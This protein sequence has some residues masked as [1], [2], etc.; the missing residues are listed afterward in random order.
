MPRFFIA[1]TV[2]E[3][4]EQLTLSA[5]DTHHILHVLRLK[6]GDPMTVCDGSHTIHSCI[7]EDLPSAGEALTVRIT[8]RRKGQA[9]PPYSVTLY[10]GIP[11]GDKMGTVVRMAVEL[12]VGRIVPVLCDR[13]VSRPAG[14]KGKD[15]ALRW[16]KVATAAAK[17][18]GRD[19]I[20]TVSAPLT[21]KEALAELLTSG[22]GARPEEKK[23]GEQAGLPAATAGGAGETDNQ[24]RC[25]LLFAP[26][27]GETET[28]LRSWLSAA[29]KNRPA[30]Q[31]E[32]VAFF[33]GPEGGF[34]GAEEAA[35]AAAGV[36]TVSL[37]NR[38]LRTETAA[39]AVLSMLSYE[40]EMA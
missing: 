37:G 25:R 5:D 36:A 31:P 8:D 22:S 12:G 10:Q 1:E 33:I 38:I 40:L 2:A 24:G 11:K 27:E 29:T 16:Q 3:Q 26:Y 18:S 4:A 14:N 6:R 9:E 39:A 21:F 23:T 19:L 32:Q 35:L 34:S 7:L 20:P 13:S 15:K 30:D 28:S 17:Q